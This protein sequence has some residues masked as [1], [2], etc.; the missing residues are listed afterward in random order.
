MKER[1]N[2]RMEKDLREA[3]KEKNRICKIKKDKKG[4]KV[5]GKQRKK[6]GK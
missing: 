2:A 1:K 3:E 5:E 6:E 4:R